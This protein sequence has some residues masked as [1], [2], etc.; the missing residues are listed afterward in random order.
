MKGHFYGN[1]LIFC[2]DTLILSNSGIHTLKFINLSRKILEITPVSRVGYDDVG[3]DT[4]MSRECLQ[5]PI[6]PSYFE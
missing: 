1:D 3:K 2:S 4:L 6:C 5:T